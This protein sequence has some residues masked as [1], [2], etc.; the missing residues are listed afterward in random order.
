MSREHI[1]NGSAILGIEFGST[2]IKSVLIA[3][4]HS[5]IASGSHEWENDFVDGVWTYSQQA[6]LSGLKSSY[7]DLKKNIAEQYGVVP[8]KL[9]AIGISAM[10]HGY[11]PFDADMNLLAPFRTWRNTITAEAAAKLSEAFSF[12]MPQRWSLSHL[13][14]AIL[15]KEPHVADIRYLTTLAGWVHYLLTGKKVLGVGDASGMMPIDSTSCDYDEKMVRIFDELVAPC[16]FPWKLRDIMPRVLSA[17]AD[18]GCLTAEGACLL[19]DSG[20]LQPGCPLCPPEGDAG[21]GMAATNSVRERTGNVSAGTSI[22]SMIVLEKPFSAVYPEIDVVTTPTGRQVGMVHCNSCTSDINAWVSLFREFAEIMG[23]ETNAGE[24]YTRLFRKAMEGEKDCGGIV[25]FNYFAGEP[26]TGLAEGRPMLIRTPGAKMNMANFMRAQVCAS[27][28]TLKAGME[29]MKRE[30]VAIDCVYGHGGLFKTEGVA[31]NLLAAA[32]H[33][34]VTVMETAGEGGAWGI[35][36]LAAYTV[37]KQEGESLEDY[38][39]NRV[40]A[41]MKQMT[42]SPD[43]EDEAGFDRYMEKFLACIPAQQAA[44][45]GLKI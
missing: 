17:G 7:A 28:E 2:R 10:M 30:H 29:I 43:P 24:V 23:F 22:F 36:L 35:A 42:V 18:A 37:A 4:D 16:A 31:Q 20:D 34:P 1:V 45:D 12:N 15:N 26:V 33:A 38:L 9:A 19:D 27:M 5:V 40:F 25:S 8:K 32:I 11:L 3:P 41:G 14:Q 21:T 39:Q 6:I 44:V 13:Y